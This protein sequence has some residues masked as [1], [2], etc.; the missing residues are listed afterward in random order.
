MK[1]LDASGD[2]R[3]G[4]HYTVIATRNDEVVTPYTNAFLTRGAGATVRNIT[5]QTQCRLDQ[6][7]HLSTPFDSV[8]MADVLNALDPQHPVRVPCVPVVAG[9]G[10]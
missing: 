5:L 6:G 8:A 9:V 7:D 2:T 10:G 3:P 1:K 4:I